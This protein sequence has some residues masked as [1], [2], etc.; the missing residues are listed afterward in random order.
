[1]EQGWYRLLFAHW[2]F[3]VSQLRSLVPD[4]L[5]IDTSDGN[6]W[7]S[8]TPFEARVRPRGLGSINRLW[9]FPELNCRT[10]VR[11]GGIPGVYFFS[12]D[13]GSLLT[14]LGARTLYH[15]PYFH[16]KMK[17]DAVNS[18]IHYRCKRTLSS[19]SFYAEYEPKPTR[20]RAVNGSL[21][22]WLTERY[23]LYTVTKRTVLRSEIHHLPWDLQDVRA[24]F[25]QNTIATAAGLSL[26]ASPDLA[27]YAERQEVLIWPPYAA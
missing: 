10:Y 7:I 13:A 20:S 15:L 25:H 6:A 1:M 21:E 14:V 12:L 16:S 27:Q 18:E 9:S 3:S 2:A 8:L 5:E 24:E 11:Y 23:C 19:A 22:H 17:I 26:S 4:E